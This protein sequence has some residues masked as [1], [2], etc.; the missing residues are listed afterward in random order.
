MSSLREWHDFDYAGEIEKLF[1]EHSF[2][3]GPGAIPLKVVTQ[4]MLKAVCGYWNGNTAYHI[5]LEL[6]LIKETKKGKP[7]ATIK[8]KE[9]LWRQ[10]RERV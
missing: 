2:N 10:L 7:R 5:L 6:K 9:F 8:G 4:A 1:A 3:F